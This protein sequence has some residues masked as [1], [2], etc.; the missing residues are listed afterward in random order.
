MQSGILF[1]HQENEL[2]S[3]AG[4]Q[5]ELDDV[6]LI[7]ITQTHKDKYLMFLFK[8]ESSKSLFYRSKE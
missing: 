2:L 1:S 8:S 6:L 5:M 4:T 3:V 7:K